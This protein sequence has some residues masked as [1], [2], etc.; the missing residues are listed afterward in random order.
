MWNCGQ[1]IAQNL[2]C[3]LVINA[4]NFQNSREYLFKQPGVRPLVEA[5]LAGLV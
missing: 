4:A 1:R 5:A 2:P 3:T